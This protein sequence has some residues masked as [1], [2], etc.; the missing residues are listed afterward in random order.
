[1]KNFTKNIT[2]K[3]KLSSEVNPVILNKNRVL[4]E[5]QPPDIEDF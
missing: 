4:E 5:D 3:S 1:M 2:V